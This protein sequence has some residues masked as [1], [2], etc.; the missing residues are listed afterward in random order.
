MSGTPPHS[1]NTTAIVESKRTGE[2]N[3][4]EDIQDEVYF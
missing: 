1:Q 3:W 4:D 2:G